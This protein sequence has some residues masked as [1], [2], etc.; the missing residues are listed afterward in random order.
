MKYIDFVHGRGTILNELLSKYQ[1]A[2]KPI[3]KMKLRSMFW[4]SKVTINVDNSQRLKHKKVFEK[5]LHLCYKY[6]KSNMIHLA[7]GLG[8][9]Q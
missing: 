4:K 2:V 1:I 9:V 5:C 8:I 3:K 7:L 6:I